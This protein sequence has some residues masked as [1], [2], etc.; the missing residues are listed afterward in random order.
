[1]L[2]DSCREV[3]DLTMRYVGFKEE[4]LEGFRKLCATRLR[5]LVFFR[6]NGL[7]GVEW[8]GI[9]I[10]HL[11][12]LEIRYLCGRDAA[13]P[14]L[15]MRISAQ[16]PNLRTL[17]WPDDLDRNPGS[18]SF[19]QILASCPRL[20]SLDIRGMVIPDDIIAT[21]LN[22][23]AHPAREIILPMTRFTFDA[24]RIAGFG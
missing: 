3:V 19:H 5:R 15:R 23:M 1:M 13:D 10:P 20:E 6:S 12:E 8:D 9:L 7:K 4:Y 11:Q 2:L 21:F 16:C 14:G 17:R 18:S 24:R 22:S